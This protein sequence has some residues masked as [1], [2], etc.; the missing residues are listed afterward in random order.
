MV[1]LGEKWTLVCNYVLQIWGVSYGMRKQVP[2]VVVLEDTHG[3]EISL[4][5]RADMNY[6]SDWGMEWET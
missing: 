2:I 5:G 3:T 6:L 1:S 4:E